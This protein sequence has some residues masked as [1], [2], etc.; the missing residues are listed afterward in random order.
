MRSARRWPRT[1]ELVAVLEERF[2]AFGP[3]P[4]ANRRQ[5]QLIPSAEAVPNPI[6]S[7]PG[8]WVERDGSV[9]AL[10]PGV[11]S[12]MRL[13]WTD[14]L[15]PRLAAALRPSA[16][17]DPHGE[18][19]RHRRVGARRAARRRCSTRH[20]PASRP[21]ST[22]A[23]TAST[24]GSRRAGD[25]A[26]LDALVE[27]TRDGARRAR[28]RRRRRGPGV[29]RPRAPRRARARRRWRAGRPTPR[30]R[31]SRSSRPRRPRR[32][33]RASSAACS[34]RAAPSGP[35][36]GDAVVQLSLLPQ[37]AHGR[38]RVRVARQR[39]GLDADDRAAH[40]RLRA[41]ATPARRVRRARR[42]SAALAPATDEA[43]RRRPQREAPVGGRAD[44][45]AV[46]LHRDGVAVE[47]V[48]PMTSV[49]SMRGACG[50][51]P[52]AQRAGLEREARRRARD[53]CAGRAGPASGRAPGLTFSPRP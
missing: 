13:M 31:C 38:S 16:A 25:P 27:P 18:G 30:A 50:R 33:R 24:C 6:G 10:M 44:E 42:G 52:S 39:R 47:R 9:V 23:T 37:D 34:T 4:A 46:G 48:G 22:R 21:E 3:M 20:R 8:W 29:G 45:V 28:L 11:P 53:R 41:A 2:R 5:A 51:T 14:Q 43:H 1:A 7:A 49:A 17:G 32:V 19:V 12:E 36:V 35:P 15:R 26:A 40:P